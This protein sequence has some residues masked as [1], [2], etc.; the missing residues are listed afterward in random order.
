MGFLNNLFSYFS[1]YNS[2]LINS[3]SVIFIIFIENSLK[4][5][6]V[7][8]V[9]DLK[10]S[11]KQNVLYVILLSVFMVCLEFFI[12]NNYNI[13]I[14]YI[15]NFILIY[16]IFKMNL[17]KTFLT[18][19]ISILI[20]MFSYIF[21]LVPFIKI[22]N[23][24]YLMIQQIPLYYITFL[25]IFYAI[26]A[27]FLIAINYTKFKIDSLD[28]L[29]R[30]SKIL[31]TIYNIFSISLIYFFSNNCLK[32]D[33]NI[34]VNYIFTIFYFIGNMVI[35][36]LITKYSSLKL[37]LEVANNYNQ[38]L[39]NINDTVRAF[40]HDFANII[41]SIGGFISTND[42]L[43]LKKFYLSLETD[44]NELNNLYTLNPELISNSGVYNLLNQK[45]N[46]AVSNGIKFNLSYFVDIN[47][48]NIS[49]YEL[50]RILG[51]L[52]DNAIDA[53]KSSHEKILNVSFK[54][55]PKKH[56]NVIVVQNSYL[57]KNLDIDDIFR[58]GITSKVN[59]TGLGLWEVKKI[60]GKN[61]NLDL[62]TS[63]DDLLFTQQLE[64]YDCVK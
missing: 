21:V 60:L 43:G 64:I 31:F 17:F 6:L 32:L 61:P 20:F 30:K 58:K 53:A 59:H 13:F 14:G 55:E 4:L 12:D 62:Y 37:D 48:F 36:I 35:Y 9:S 22:F 54:S 26:V 10:T 49:I 44:Y 38:V 23:I 50:T 7:K 46:L 39:S 29:N 11:T 34:F 27:L 3:F 5:K 41:A 42:M 19:L 15:F 52:I 24:S 33:E 18:V 57:D 1:S 63:K 25:L 47:N 56:R 45:Y 2:M 51:I 28:C 16:F 40:K 8:L